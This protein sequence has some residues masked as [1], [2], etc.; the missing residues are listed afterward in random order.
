MKGSTKIK[1]ILDELLAAELAAINTYFVN[2]KLLSNWGYATLAAKIYEE[3]MAEMRHAEQLIDRIIYLDAV[4]N[5]NKL[6]RVKTGATVGEQFDTA[7][8]LE[9]GQC[10]RLV[11][12]VDTCRA[13]GDDGTRLILEPMIS[14]G[15]E[16]IDWLET[17][18]SLIAKLGETNYLAQQLGTG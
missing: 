18:I 2:A 7:L 1:G 3:S 13:E 6:G 12:A 15:E 4:P 16:T 9:M 17:Q 8:E 11:Q 10:K 14:A 5:M